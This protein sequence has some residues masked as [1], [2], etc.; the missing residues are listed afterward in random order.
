[1]IVTVGIEL[2]TPTEDVE[3]WDPRILAAAREVLLS[4][5]QVQDVDFTPQPE[6]SYQPRFVVTLEDDFPGAAS[7]ATTTL[8][9]GLTRLA[10]VR[11]IFAEDGGHT[12][13]L[14]ELQF[15]VTP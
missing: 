6:E 4:R 5:T 2:S 14:V 1:M 8:L 11:L 3:V 12:A 7:W 13:R 9:R 15:E 10:T